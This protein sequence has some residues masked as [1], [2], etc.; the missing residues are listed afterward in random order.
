MVPS[1]GTFAKRGFDLPEI[2]FALSCTSLSLGP[3]ETI[4]LFTT[5]THCPLYLDTLSKLYASKFDSKLL[6]F[7]LI[8]SADANALKYI[9]TS[10]T[11]E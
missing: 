6:L 1:R 9:K 10:I 7:I 8:L 3:E 11:I 4:F 2:F 5:A